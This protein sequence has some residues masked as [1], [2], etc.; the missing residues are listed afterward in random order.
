V[1]LRDVLPPSQCDEAVSLFWD[2]LEGLGS[3]L[4]RDDPGTWRS[5]AWPGHQA[6]GFRTS[7]GASQCAAAWLVRSHPSVVRAFSHLW[8][9]DDLLVSLDSPI[10]W[11]PW[12]L[13]S[14]WTP[15]VERLH[16]DQIPYHK[17]GFH[18]VQGMVPLL[19]QDA[20]SGGLQLAPRSHTDA[21]QQHLRQAYPHLDLDPDDWCELAPGDPFLGTGYLP[22]AGRGDLNLWDSRLI[23]GGLVGTGPATAGAP[24][25]GVPGAKDS[26]WVPPRLI[27]GGLVGIGP[28][29]SARAR[30]S[31]GQRARGSPI[32]TIPGGSSE[33]PCLAG[34]ASSSVPG[35]KS[36]AWQVQTGA[37]GGIPNAP[38]ENRAWGWNWPQLARLCLNLPLLA[39]LRA[40]R[41]DL[42][43]HRPQLARLSC[44]VCM[45]ER[46]RGTA[47]ALQQRRE[48]VADGAA[49][50]HGPHQPTRHTLGDTGGGGIKGAPFVPP[51]LSAAQLALVG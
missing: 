15:V 43:W 29:P 50:T 14:S 47:N 33:S 13:N 32:G 44:T 3:E 24:S 31:S 19:G 12:W 40:Q 34:Q 26:V 42:A 16:V 6:F 27:H 35:A 28:T 37:A 1:V 45:T 11:R 5:E 38:R 7:H 9:T 10:A 39:R 49:L 20:T 21:V 41:E 8:R 22:V 2:W 51:S 25:S 30:G 18:C 36:S 17:R 4:R 48:A 23:H 46:R